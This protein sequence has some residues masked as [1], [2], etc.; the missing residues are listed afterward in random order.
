LSEVEPGCGGGHRTILLGI[1]RLVAPLIKGDI[2]SL[3][4]GWERNMAMPLKKGFVDS[5]IELNYFSF[6]AVSYY[7]NV[8]IVTKGEALTRFVTFLLGDHGDPLSLLFQRVE[9]E[10]LKASSPFAGPIEAGLPHLRVVEDQERVLW[11]KLFNTE[12]RTI[13][14][15]APL[16]VNHQKTALPPLVGGVLGNQLIG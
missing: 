11:E 7:S 8:N 5:F 10:E 6:R 12:D 14:V 9:E 16:F 1:D 13:C 15:S 2:V 4:I 3:D